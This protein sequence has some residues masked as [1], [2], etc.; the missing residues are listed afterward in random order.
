MKA[1][2][3]HA[4]AAAWLL[5]AALVSCSHEKK[6]AA[7]PP[8]PP[9]KPTAAEES[10]KAIELA[11]QQQAQLVD[12]QKKVESSHAAVVAAQDQ[13]VKA[14]AQEQQERAKAQQLQEQAN[15]NFQEGMLQA[16]RAQAGLSGGTDG[17][18]TVAGTVAQ[19]SSSQVVLQTPNGRTMS[20]NVDS[21]TRVLVGSESR[22]VTDIQRGADAQVAY[23]PTKTG[24]KNALIIRVMPAGSAT[25]GSAPG[26]APGSSAPGGEPP[27][28]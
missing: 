13:L 3:S 22:S 26:S 12:Q 7:P 1:P 19:A 2:F 18:Q 28:R 21:R 10:Q 15:R 11:R 24:Q 4:G 8:A 25:Q 20:F 6:A 17:M 9:P 27:H 16:Q 23:D 5:A 14:Q